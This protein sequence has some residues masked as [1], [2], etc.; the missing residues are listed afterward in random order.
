[1]LPLVSLPHLNKNRAHWALRCRQS[2]RERND[3]HRIESPVSIRPFCGVVAR[4]NLL[5]HSRPHSSRSFV[6]QIGGVQTCR[7]AFLPRDSGADWKMSDSRGIVTTSKGIERG[8]ISLRRCLSALSDITTAFDLRRLVVNGCKG[9]TSAVSFW[10]PL[11]K[12]PA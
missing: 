11:N 12:R 6:D 9:L 10:K 8:N 4:E 3:N 7:R 2:R 5:S 1:M